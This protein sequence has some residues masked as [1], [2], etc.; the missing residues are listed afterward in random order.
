M[1]SEPTID[2]VD[3]PDKPTDPD[4]V[5]QPRESQRV[6]KVSDGT[7]RHTVRIRRDPDQ[8]YGYIVENLVAGKWHRLLT[9]DTID[10][11]IPF[12]EAAKR[13]AAVLL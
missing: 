2:L 7:A 12:D 9:G 6:Y 8:G 3:A 10:L 4:D 1:V 13:A 11:R 5:Y